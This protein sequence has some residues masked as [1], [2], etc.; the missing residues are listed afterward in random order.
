LFVVYTLFFYTT[1]KKHLPPRRYRRQETPPATPPSD[2]DTEDSITVEDE[3]QPMRKKLVQSTVRAMSN[4]KL[5]IHRRPYSNARIQVW[6]GM[7]EAT[8]CTAWVDS[9]ASSSYVDKDSLQRLS[10][11]TEILRLKMP[12]SIHIGGRVYRT[13]SYVSLQVFFPTTSGEMAHFRREFIV[14]EDFFLPGLLI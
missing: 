1:A 9:G 10:P 11:A 2:Q 7:S 3:E 13:D 4:I 8:E 6:L 14:L 12:E 5:G